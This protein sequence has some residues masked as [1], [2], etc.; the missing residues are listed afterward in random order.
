[1]I[2]SG[3]QRRIQV[4]IAAFAL[5]L[6]HD[7]NTAAQSL[8]QTK[9]QYAPSPPPTIGTPQGSG[10]GAGSRGP[11]CKRYENV[12]ALVPLTQPPTQPTR[13]G[14]TTREYPT[15]WLSAPQGLAASVPIELVIQEAAGQNRFRTVVQTSEVSAG[16]FSL[17][18][19]TAAPPLQIGKTYRWSISI[20]CD[21]DAIDIPVTVQGLIQRVAL[22]SKLQSQ[23][24]TTH[25]VSEQANLYARNGLWYDALTTLGEGL[26]SHDDPGIATALKDLLRQA[27][28][29]GMVSTAI[30]PCCK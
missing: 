19:P 3:I 23:I 16:I 11:A 2:H 1:M 12:T 17:A 21:P 30:V 28:L 10:R 13:W 7:S 24:A 15:I 4:F 6:V 9:I 5:V 8:F 22:P 29:N 25:N 18:L 14:L 20:Y 27:N 26:R